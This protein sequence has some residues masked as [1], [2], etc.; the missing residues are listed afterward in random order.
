MD[1]HM[2]GRPSAGGPYSSPGP[3]DVHAQTPLL[4]SSEGT[5]KAH[6]EPE[7]PAKGLETIPDRNENGIRGSFCIMVK[8]RAFTEH[9]L[10]PALSTGRYSEELI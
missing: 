10:H 5:L 1:G 9:F 3:R 4:G 2:P 8:T 6:P 7:R